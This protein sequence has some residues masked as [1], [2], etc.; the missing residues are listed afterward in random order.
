VLTCENAAQGQAQGG[1]L[2]ALNEKAAGS[3]GRAGRQ[4]AIGP[5]FRTASGFPHFYP[6]DLEMRTTVPHRSS[7]DRPA[8]LQR[9]SQPLQ[10]VA[11]ELVQE[12][13]P[14]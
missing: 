10:G 5:A 2:S 1:L 6:G 8:V 12:E 13:L 4:F 9:L 14:W 3:P 11:P 7:H